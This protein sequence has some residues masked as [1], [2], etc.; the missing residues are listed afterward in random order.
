LAK[1]IRERNLSES[2]FRSFAENIAKDLGGDIER[3]TDL[4]YRPTVDQFN[5]IFVE[6]FYEFRKTVKIKIIVKEGGELPV[7]ATA[8]SSGADIKAAEDFSLEPGE[9][10][11]IHTGLYMQLPENVEVQCRPRSGLAL[12]KGITCLNAPGT[13][14]ADYRGEVGVPLINLSTE[15]QTI[16]NGDRVAQIVFAPYA[17]V[18][19][20]IEVSDVSEMTDTE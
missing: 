14:D 15:P 9:R 19:E 2:E 1:L 6:N 17:K 10:R 13:I 18:E 4:L 16:E 12:K 20:I 7:Y 5:Q 8:Q 11:M 3:L